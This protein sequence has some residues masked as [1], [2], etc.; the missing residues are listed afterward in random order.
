VSESPEMVTCEV[1][2]DAVPADETVTLHGKRVGARGKQILIERLETGQKIDDRPEAPSFGQRFG[3]SFLDGIIVALFSGA[4]GLAGGLLLAQ[5]QSSLDAVRFGAIFQLIGV[6][7]GVA[8]FTF[9]HAANGQTV[10]KRV[11]KT[12]AVMLDG[13]PMWMGSAFV[14]ALAFTGVQALMPLLL[15]IGGVGIAAAA[16]IVNIVVVV[17][18]LANAITVLASSDKRALHDMIAGTRVIRTDG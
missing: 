17:Y 1:T 3:A 16:G 7:I 9:Q 4:L 18:L 6:A 5:S 15:L 12:R 11:A 14:R 13:S 10:G 8:Y 2:G